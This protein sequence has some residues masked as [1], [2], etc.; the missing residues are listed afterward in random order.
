MCDGVDVVG[1]AFLELKE[2]RR[3]P[4]TLTHVTSNVE[5][6]HRTLR[7]AQLDRGLDLVRQ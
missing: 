1:G 5:K 3:L 6:I 2:G 7:L 4:V